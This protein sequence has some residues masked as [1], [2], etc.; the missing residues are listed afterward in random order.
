MPAPE[1]PIAHIP[2]PPTDPR[3]R[4]LLAAGAALLLLLGAA[5]QAIGFRA[6]LNFRQ[7]GLAYDLRLRWVETHYVL[8]GRN[9]TDVYNASKGD[10][11]AYERE[12]GRRAAPRADLGVPKDAGYPPWSYLFGALAFWPPW[13][14]VRGYWAAFNVAAL[15]GTV[16][17]AAAR[18]RGSGPLA[19]LLAGAVLACSSDATTLAMGQAGLVMVGMLAGS[20]ALMERR[21][22]WAA[23]LLLGLA[24]FK[25][26]TAAPFLFAAL[27]AGRWRAVVGA[28]AY[29]ALAAGA[30]WARVGVDPLVMTSHT[31]KAATHYLGDG[32]GPVNWLLAAGLTGE[33]AGRAAAA[34]VFLIAAPSMWL[35][36][37]RGPTVL[38]A[39]AAV[40]CRLWTYHRSWDD[41]VLLFV[42]VPLLALAA[43]GRRP[44]VWAAALGVGLS[45]W[46]PARLFVPDRFA[47]ATWTN[48][49]Q[50]IAWV[51]GA[52]TL[53]LAADPAPTLGDP[54]P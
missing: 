33:A 3:G 37:R 29:L 43:S 23:G 24:M 9:P 18:A 16:A 30:T 32:T 13:P 27:V 6:L 40:A 50:V 1:T 54:R 10:L 21:R 8:G 47:Y 52:A 20:L 34:G 26:T 25:P 53:A 5:Y 36:R 2:D 38:F 28:G 19:A 17:W 41:N 45:L 44:G 51:V 12:T 31:L 22:D 42:L 46:L 4:R 14:A 35:A 39:I 15:A 7:E 11:G 48:V 49:L